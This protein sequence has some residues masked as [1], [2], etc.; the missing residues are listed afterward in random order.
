MRLL[1]A[2]L[3][4]PLA[5]W[6][7]MFV[8]AALG[9]RHTKLSDFLLFVVYLPFAYAAALIV[10]VP[11]HLFLRRRGIS[12]WWLYACLGGAAASLVSAVSIALMPGLS[13]STSDWVAVCAAGVTS[14]LLFRALVG[15]ESN[16][17]LSPSH[18]SDTALAHSSKRRSAGRAG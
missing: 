3:I 5:A 8:V 16:S 7:A 17:A 4:S 2:V 13:A 12:A 6:P 14:G 9:S 10:G 15:P 18:S 1:Y 11:V